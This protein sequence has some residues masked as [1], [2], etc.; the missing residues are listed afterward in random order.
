MA[1]EDAGSPSRSEEEV[2]DAIEAR[3]R[4]PRRKLL[5]EQ[6]TLS[7]GAGGKSSHDL[8][9]ALFLNELRNPLLEPLGDS[10]LLPTDGDGRR[11]AFTTDS[12][13]VRPLFFPGGDIGEL[14]VNGTVNDLAM[15][16][17][18]PLALSAGFIIEEGLP[19]ADLERIVAS[20]GAAARAA[21]VEVATGDTKVVER[22]KA[23]GLYINTAGVGVVERD[24]EL[25][26]ASIE[27][28]DRVLVSGP[29]GDHGMAIMVAR[30]ELALEV[31]LESDTAPLYELVVSLLDAAGEGVR[32]M[33]DPTRGGLATVLAE[34]ALAAEL[35]IS[36]DEAAVP[37]RPEVIGA[38]EILG[39]DPLY[40]ANEGKLVAV[41]AADAAEAALAALRAHP[42]GA[43]AAI[44]AEIIPEPPGL[45]LL[46]TSFG[47][48]RVVDMLAGDPLPRIC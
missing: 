43:E 15:A 39:I 42:L 34:L 29:V 14:A 33:R 4:R 7:H 19:V 41:V 2:L 13:V 23:D 21:G 10:A 3:R 36:I 18:R 37:I 44:V 25:S 35:G 28:G 45:V 1:V 46:E 47:G 20:M 5:D 30:G 17:A 16:G 32:W 12:F 48:S 8:I 24:L 31:D 22:G 26:P 6:I 9:E 27:P 11:L 40:V 38:C